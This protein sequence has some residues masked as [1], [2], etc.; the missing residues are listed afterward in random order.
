MNIKEAKIRLNKNELFLRFLCAVFLLGLA[1]TMSCEGDGPKIG[2]DGSDADAD[3]D[4]DIDADADSDIDVDTNNIPGDT[5]NNGSDT[6]ICVGLEAIGD[7]R[8]RMEPS[9]PACGDAEIN[10]ESEECDDGNTL[11]GDGCNGICRVEPNW[12]CPKPG[13]KC[14]LLI[15]CGNGKIEPGEV[16]D[17]GN[18]I[19]DDGCNN[20]CEQSP[21]YICPR[22]N[23]A[24]QRVVVCNDGRIGGDETCEDGNTISGDGCDENCHREDGWICLI[25]GQKCVPRNVCGD[26]ILS[27]AD[28][29]KCD[30]GNT[31][32]GDGCAGDCKSIESGY[33]CP[34][35]GK[36]C[37][38]TTVCGDGRVSGS[39]TCDDAN[40]DPADGCDNCALQPGYECPF[41]GAKCLAKCGDG[42]ILLN[43]E[44]DDGNTQDGDGCTST[45]EWE[46]G[47]ICTGT[48]PNYVCRE[49]VCGD[50]KV[51]GTEACDDGNNNMGDGCTPFCDK[52]P[53]CNGGA[54]TSTCGDSLLLTSMG[55]ECDDGNARDGD[56]CS[57]SCKIE[58]GFQCVQPP[59]GD[60][61][62]I[63]LVVRDFPGTHA[64]FENGVTGSVDATLGLVKDT[65][66][67]D[68]KPVFAGANSTGHIA[69]AASFAEWFR[70]ASSNTTVVT[71]LTLYDNGNGGYVNR[72][73]PDGEP[74]AY[75]TDAV[76]CGNGGAGCT[77][78]TEDQYDV[79]LD[80]CTY[81]GNGN[82]SACGVQAVYMEGNP[83]FFPA[84]G[85]AGAT[86][87]SIA[88][89]PP[90]YADSWPAEFPDLDVADQ[91]KHN[92]AF[93]SEVRYWFQYNSAQ[94]Y[95]LDFLGDDDVW[96]FLN[97]KLAVDLGGIHTPV[98]GNLTIAGLADGTA[99]GMEDGKVYEIVVFQAERQTTCSS[100]QLTLSGF[101]AAETKCGPICGDAVM[102]PGEQCDNGDAENTGGYGKC[103][104]DC[105]RGPYCGDG[106]VQNDIDSVTGEPYEQCDDGV[107][108]SPYSIDMTSGCSPGCIQ[109]PYCGDGIVQGAFGETCDDG[110]ND[111]SYGGCS[112]TCGYAA[113]CGD[114]IK[115]EAFGE[116]CDDGLNDGTYNTCSPGCK[117]PP[118]CGDG[119]LQIEWGEQ[120]EIGEANC[121]DKCN[122]LGVCG[123]GS[124]DDGEEC[125]DGVNDGGY[126]E[127]APECKLGP[128]CGD[129][130][131]ET[132][133]NPA[134][135]NPYEL[136]DDRNN[137]GGYG[138]CAPGCVLGPRCGDGIPQ[139]GYEE[140]DEGEKN[141]TSQSLCT[142]ACKEILIIPI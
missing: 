88:Q 10:Q 100:Y 53:I 87:L 98:A 70:D 94:T 24:C 49:T 95:T 81:W 40:D 136:C 7:P 93:T 86:P 3:S 51:E 43:E 73:G 75:Y 41:P 8:C 64:D 58:P 16:C 122:W 32:D 68:G 78:C 115:Q 59:I 132:S 82:T 26:S 113:W 116:E 71:S 37:V 56:G 29:E 114:G 108:V 142:S 47:F 48:P 91:P 111:G 128:Y 19:D 79:C 54:C 97:N 52:E 62:T 11:P 65:L 141:G 130:A 121:S 126:G 89:I 124:V 28:G 80:P 135:S 57:S 67:A 103:Q 101:N 66:D 1:A 14:T 105:T 107:N 36:Q 42:I 69:S 22:P 50:S 102:S 127:C 25:P 110:V 44:C 45:C 92:F 72:W 129:G 9:G 55:E 30:D 2:K 31:R 33:V 34:E 119:I 17:D 4:S 106:K 23:E 46:D 125:D 21:N 85:I 12:V 120:C 76:W 99:Y 27:A 20:K 140:C 109:P 138:E 63:P 13:E 18:N 5:D 60:K 74:F 35:A 118:R 134:T 133:I 137:K 38:N 117:A 6:A 112:S 96:V 139:P 39:E 123:D 131:V 15:I 77:E 83:V 84:D 104:P 90:P 61:M